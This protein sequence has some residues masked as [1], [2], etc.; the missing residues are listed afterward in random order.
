VEEVRNFLSQVYQIIEL[1]H[2]KN[3]VLGNISVFSFRRASEF[4]SAVRMVELNL[5]PG[6]EDAMGHA[7]R[8]EK[9]MD[10]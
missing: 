2:Q 9:A 3:I 10:W 5:M 8:G 1:F 7:F 4:D 6:Y